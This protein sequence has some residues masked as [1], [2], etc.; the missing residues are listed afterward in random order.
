MRVPLTN[1]GTRTPSDSTTPPPDTTP[2]PER[3]LL[4]RSL[5]HRI[6][7]PSS[8]Y[9]PRRKS[10][11]SNQ[12]S[13]RGGTDSVA[14]PYRCTGDW[15]IH[16]SL[17]ISLDTPTEIQTLVP[18]QQPLRTTVSEWTARSEEFAPTP[19]HLISRDLMGCDEV[20]IFRLG[21]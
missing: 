16:A 5:Y 15:G 4:H 6:R 21:I 13:T 2:P 17:S 9:K 11:K 8:G 20:I 19:E 10:A 18:H 3:S 7:H 12:T 1:T 14:G